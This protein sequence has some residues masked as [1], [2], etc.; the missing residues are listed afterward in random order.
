M[1]L[2]LVS[3]L[4]KDGS[5]PSHSLTPMNNGSPS[6]HRNSNVSSPVAARS[7]LV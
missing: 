7:R 6:P 4:K 5:T 1:L 3:T 2:P